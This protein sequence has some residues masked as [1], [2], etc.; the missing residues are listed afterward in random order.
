MKLL[1]ILLTTQLVGCATLPTAEQYEKKTQT[2]Q[3]CMFNAIMWVFAI[4]GNGFGDV[5]H[6]CEKQTK[7]SL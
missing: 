2:V 7:E 5:S 3:T 4:P 1:L 6:L